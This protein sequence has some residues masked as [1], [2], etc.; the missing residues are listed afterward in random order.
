MFSGIQEILIIVLIVLGVF[1]IPRM[2]SSRAPQKKVVLRRH[3][4]R[5]SWTIRLSIVLSFLWP[6]ACAAYFKPWQQA[7]IPFVMIGVG[8]IVVGWSARWIVAGMKR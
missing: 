6:L 7:T 4:R 8:P 5:L 3:T 2:V 1:L